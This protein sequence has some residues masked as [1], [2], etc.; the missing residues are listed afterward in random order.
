MFGGRLLRSGNAL[1]NVLIENWKDGETATDEADI[2][3]CDSRMV[4]LV[5]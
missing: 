2:H 4:T 1:E 3:L 5:G